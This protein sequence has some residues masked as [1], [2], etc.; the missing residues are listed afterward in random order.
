MLCAILLGYGYM[1]TLLSLRHAQLSPK[2]ANP[3]PR[4]QQD[5]QPRPAS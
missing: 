2:L 1:A 3:I 4:L 5:I